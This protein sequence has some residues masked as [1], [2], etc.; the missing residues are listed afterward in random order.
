MIEAATASHADAIIAA[1]IA[2]VGSPTVL[3]LALKG[4]LDDRYSTTNDLK[5]A[6]ARMTAKIDDVE[7]DLGED[8]NHVGA[9]HSALLNLYEQT[10]GQLT[11][12]RDRCTKMEAAQNP[13]LDALGRFEKK[14]DQWMDRQDEHGRVLA[15]HA[16]QIKT[17]FNERGK[18]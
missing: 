1:L 10:Q 13:V 14:M 12:V 17:L 6:E 3:W 5:A 15:V 4:K 16:E 18:S 7:E 8:V 11:E 2:S 9:K